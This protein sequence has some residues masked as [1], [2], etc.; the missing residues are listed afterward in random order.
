MGIRYI[1][2]LIMR[3]SWRSRNMN[4]LFKIKYRSFP[5]DL[6]SFQCFVSFSKRKKRLRYVR[7][8]YEG[9]QREGNVRNSIYIR[10]DWPLYICHSNRKL[11]TFHTARTVTTLWKY[12][13]NSFIHIPVTV[14]SVHLFKSTDSAYISCRSFEKTPRGARVFS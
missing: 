11:L 9:F 3:F 4:I 2:S 8:K 14:Q 12:S 7:L 13:K 5:S 1:I 6:A 10:T